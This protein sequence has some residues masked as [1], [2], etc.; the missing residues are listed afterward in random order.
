MHSNAKLIEMDCRSVILRGRFVILARGKCIYASSVSLNKLESI[1]SCL[2]GDFL[3]SIIVLRRLH[4]RSHDATATRGI[5][6]FVSHKG[7]CRP[8]GYAW[9][10][11]Y[12]SENGYKLCLC[13]LVWN[14]VWFLRKLR[15]CMNVFIVSIPN[16]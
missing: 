6:L 5:I 10:A 3:Q 16:V 13:I 15:E 2:V 4:L 7:M 9:F 12:W 8:K 1:S 11:P 14:R